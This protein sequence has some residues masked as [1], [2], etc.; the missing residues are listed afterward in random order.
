[1][2]KTQRLLN[3]LFY[4]NRQGKVT[5]GELSAEFGISVRTVQRDLAELE[6]WGFL[7]IVNRGRAEDTRFSKTISCRRLFYRG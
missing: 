2:S 4:I 6:E 7:Y 3:I 1:M 5:A